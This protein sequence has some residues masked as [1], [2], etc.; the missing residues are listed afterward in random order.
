MNALEKLIPMLEKAIEKSKEDGYMYLELC[1]G[2][3]IFANPNFADVTIEMGN[4]VSV[5]KTVV[6]KD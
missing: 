4:N 6:K 3:R 1:D 5:V 2:V